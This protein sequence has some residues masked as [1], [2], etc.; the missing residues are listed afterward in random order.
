MIFSEDEVQGASDGPGESEPS[1]EE[2]D[3][4]QAPIEFE[5][6]DVPRDMGMDLRPMN[7]IVAMAPTEV[8]LCTPHALLVTSLRKDHPELNFHTGV[9]RRRFMCKGTPDDKLSRLLALMQQ[10]AQ[11]SLEPWKADWSL[12]R[13]A[14]HEYEL[15]CSEATGMSRRAVRPFTH[16]Q[17]TEAEPATR[18]AWACL[19]AIR[20]RLYDMSKK[21]G[22]AKVRVRVALPAG[23]DMPALPVGASPSKPIDASIG[24][25]IGIMRTFNTDWHNEM[26]DASAIM[27][28]ARVLED[29]VNALRELP[30]LREKFGQY[31]QEVQ[32]L[33]GKHSLPTWACCMELSLHSKSV[34]RIHLHDYVGPSL[35]H[36]GF[37]DPKR[38]IEFHGS[39]LRWEDMKA[40]PTLTSARGN[41]NSRKMRAVACAMYYVTAQKHGSLFSAGTRSPFTDLPVTVQACS[42]HAMQVRRE[43]G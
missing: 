23:V 22:A 2:E 15:D 31:Q 13:S 34:G 11:A 1:G 25:G 43:S 30:F 26:P 8:E 41:V 6:A 24:K 18:E 35:E 16:P 19:R 17:W 5:A 4:V 9:K 38:V 28:S 39:D 29:K 14:Y 36:V 10:N 37:D 40:F 7:E 3:D 20:E 42:C 33:A 27:A 21:N 12:R 32:R